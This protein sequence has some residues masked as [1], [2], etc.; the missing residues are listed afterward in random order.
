MKD[1][2]SYLKER[3]EDVI[4][5]IAL[6]ELHYASIAGGKL[7]AIEDLKTKSLEKLAIK[8][9]FKEDKWISTR[10]GYND[11]VKRYEEYFKRDNK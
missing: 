2:A 8:Y 11:E 10:F 3:K 7:K 9:P 5:E 4:A 6:G 1:K